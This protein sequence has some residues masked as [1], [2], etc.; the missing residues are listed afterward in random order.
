MC[1]SGVRQECKT[2]LQVDY[3]ALPHGSLFIVFLLSIF[4]FSGSPK[5]YPLTLEANK[6]ATQYWSSRHITL[7]ALHS[8]L[9]AKS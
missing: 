7:Y 4:I 2:S 1:F 9:R 3:G 5:H 6:N 8:A